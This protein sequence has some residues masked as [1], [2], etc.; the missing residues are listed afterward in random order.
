[1]SGW[2]D[3]SASVLFQ[4]KYEKLTEIA[5]TGCHFAYGQWLIEYAFGRGQ[6][7][8]YTYVSA[9]QPTARQIERSNL[10]YLIYN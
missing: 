5:G 7:F 9:F 6:C 1:M 4:S 10:L 2:F 8:R 3:V